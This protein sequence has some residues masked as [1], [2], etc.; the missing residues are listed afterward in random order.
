MKFKI[1]FSGR[2][3]AYTEEEV[4]TVVEAMQTASPLTQGK[5]LKAFE[6]KF[7]KY[8]HNHSS[9]SSRITHPRAGC[10]MPLVNATDVHNTP[11]HDDGFQPGRLGPANTSHVNATE[12]P[13]E[14]YNV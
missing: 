5:Y 7:S 14:Q 4:A 8:S 11:R 6:G 12:T 1:P 2:A 13:K 10:V 3:H 9:R